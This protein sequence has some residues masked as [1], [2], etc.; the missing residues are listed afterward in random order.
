MTT[1]KTKTKGLKIE[2][3]KYAKPQFQQ[4][5]QYSRPKKTGNDK[6]ARAHFQSDDALGFVMSPDKG[7]VADSKPSC[8][9]AIIT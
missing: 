4:K 5:N 6:T 7:V 9:F 8:K 2:H 1:H 3:I